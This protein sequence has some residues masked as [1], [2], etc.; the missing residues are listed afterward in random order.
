MMYDDGGDNPRDEMTSVLTTLGLTKNQLRA[1][2]RQGCITAEYRGTSGPFFKLRFRYEN[3]QVVRYVG[4]DVPRV[5]RLRA[6]LND[7]QANRQLQIKLKHLTRHA[8]RVLR[9]SK[10]LLGPELTAAGFHFH[11]FAVRRRNECRI[12]AEST[13]NVCE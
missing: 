7:L 3:R 11:G 5:E 8:W 13:N 12:V 6:E 4:K 1:L 2:S 10:R 9:D